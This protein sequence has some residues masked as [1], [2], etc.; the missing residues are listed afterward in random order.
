MSGGLEDIYI[1]D[2]D[3]SDSYAGLR[4]KFTK[5]RGGYVRNIRV[6]DSA[7]VDFKLWN[8][9]FNDDGEGAPTPPVVENIEID[10]LYLS[11]YSKNLTTNTENFVTP[12]CIKG[13]D[14]EK[15]YARK[16]SIKNLCMSE[17]IPE[18]IKKVEV[19]N[20]KEVFIEDLN[21]K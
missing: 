5:K 4:L 14:D 2:C 15:Y 8:V 21:I 19:E 3:H 7:F 16:I 18:N 13:I 12:I 1:W 6:K 17:K 10:G 9:P 20:A 11:G